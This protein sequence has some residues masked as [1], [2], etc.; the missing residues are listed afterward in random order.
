MRAAL[1]LLLPLCASA[2]ELWVGARDLT[3]AS[4]A[5]LW[6]LNGSASSSA[7]ADGVSV[8]F[9]P[10]YGGG[11]LA[12]LSA[13][14]LR[15]MPC[16]HSSLETMQRQL[17]DG[18]ARA[19]SPDTGAFAAAYARALPDFRAGTAGGPQ[20]FMWWSLVEDDSSGVGFP[21][22]QLAVP[23]S[24]HADAH[25]QFDA[26]LQRAQVLALAL[27]P[28]TP[29]VAQVGF[30]EQAH[31]HFA[32]GVRLAI[33]E[34]AND[35][36]GD[37]GTALAFARGAARQFNGSFGVDLSWWWG[38]LYSGVNQLP[39]SY[40][41]RHAFG[42]LFGGASVVNIEGGDGLCDGAGAPLALGRELEAFG[43]FAR[44]LFPQRGAQRAGLGPAPRPLTPVLLVLPKDHGYS[45]KPY[46]L[47]QQQGYGYA[48]LPPRTGD[49]ALRGVFNLLLPGAGFAQDPFPFGAF[50]QDDPP[51]SMWAL[52]SQTAPYAPRLADTYAAA[53]YLPFGTY[54]NRSQ[55]AADFA[56]R[57]RDPAPSRPMGDSTWGNVFDVAVAGLG[58]H[59]GYQLCVLLGPVNLTSSLK[60]QLLAYARAGGRVVLAAGV[61]GPGDGDLTGIPSLLPELRFALGAGSVTTLL[62]PWME[63]EAGLAALA[64]RVLGGAIAS[65]APV[66]LAWEEGEGW[67]VDFSASASPDGQWVHALVSNN[68]EA[69]WQGSVTFTGAAGAPRALRECN[70]ARSGAP[71]PLGGPA[72]RSVALAVAA[73]DVA[74][75]RCAAEW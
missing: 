1:L 15:L 26:Y 75:V 62:L 54:Q 34:R 25:A 31:A 19:A 71:L 16:I 39:S 7:W 2:F 14:G 43:R 55:A 20:P 22:A 74:V 29:L 61:I 35:D 8:G 41:R 36:I 11:D 73:M 49:A 50:A 63:G 18:G 12:A 45:T 51:A 66:E 52:S 56:A 42:A 10:V 13:A 4:N 67:P 17:H 59:S 58:L 3:P 69:A 40:H 24:S 48:R 65:V 64:A 68:E 38:V 72:G 9:P 53:P 46:W 44:N 60:A 33:V 47:S 21:Y 70:E 28:G 37:L 30:A 5:V 6:L 57:P 27:A 32:R 23:P